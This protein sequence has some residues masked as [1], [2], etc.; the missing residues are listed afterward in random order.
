MMSSFLLCHR[1]GLLILSVVLISKSKLILHGV[2][3]AEGI[4]AQCIGCDKYCLPYLLLLKSPS[5]NTFP[6][7]PAVCISLIFMKLPVGDNVMVSPSDLDFL[8]F[9]F[10][11]IPFILILSVFQFMAQPQN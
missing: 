11:M 2:L 5:P 10:Q 3:C 1:T 9:F 7:W 4:V 8:F 6:V